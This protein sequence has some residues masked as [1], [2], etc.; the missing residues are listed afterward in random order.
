MIKLKMNT[1]LLS[2]IE[3]STY[4]TL[5]D[6]N[7]Y[8]GDDI[9]KEYHDIIVSCTVDTIKQVLKDNGINCVIKNPSFES[10]RFYN[11]GG[12]WVNF[13]LYLCDSTLQKMKSIAY[14]NDF[15]QWIKERYKSYSGFIS[16]M[17]Y[18][19]KTYMEKL[20]NDL[21]RCAGAYLSY[22]LK[23]DTDYIKENLIDDILDNAYGSGLEYYE[24][25]DNE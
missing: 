15:I 4:G 11:Y 20:E 3:L 13:D 23:D 22:L 18:S 7:L 14:D 17:P 9:L 24:N 25:D 2:F 6:I 5:L 21:E 10:P 8:E 1:D 19:K 16:F 12:D